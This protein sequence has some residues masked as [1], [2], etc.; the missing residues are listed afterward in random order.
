MKDLKNLNKKRIDIDEIQQYLNIKDY[1]ELVNVV[2]NLLIMK[3]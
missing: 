2:T 1:I 3:Q